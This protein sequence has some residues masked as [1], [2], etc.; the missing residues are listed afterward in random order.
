MQHFAALALQT[1]LRVEVPDLLEAQLRFVEVVIQFVRQVA[2][3]ELGHL[4]LGHDLFL[5]LERVYSHY[6]AFLADALHVDLNVSFKGLLGQLAQVEQR[7]VSIHYPANNAADLA[8]YLATP[9]ANQL[10]FVLFVCIAS[11]Q[12]GFV[13]DMLQLVRTQDGPVAFAA[14]DVSVLDPLELVL[15]ELGSFVSVLV[16]LVNKSHVLLILL[17]NRVLG[18]VSDLHTQHSGELSVE[19]EVDELIFFVRF[20][21]VRTL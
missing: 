12:R 11:E 18:F 17:D 13:C 10:D 14:L 15:L 6:F 16:L 19:H 3:D 21:V 2:L 1:L 7:V 4:R 8:E 9:E 20:S 5:E